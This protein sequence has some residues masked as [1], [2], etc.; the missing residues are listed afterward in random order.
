M[1]YYTYIYHVYYVSYIYM[2]YMLSML[3]ICEQ[4]A[5]S[6]ESLNKHNIDKVKIFVYFAEFVYSMSS[7]TSQYS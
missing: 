5:S 6:F 2:L 4:E 1:L 7:F 3:C